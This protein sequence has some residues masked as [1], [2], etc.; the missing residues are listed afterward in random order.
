MALEPSKK[1]RKNPDK[2]TEDEKKLFDNINYDQIQAMTDLNT[3]R[4]L[5][6][7]MTDEGFPTTSEC[8]KE[9][10][11]NMGGRPSDEA[12]PVNIKQSEEEL[13]SFREELFEWE[14]DMKFQ[15]KDIDLDREE[16]HNR[17]NSAPIRKQKVVIG[18]NA[19]K[20]NKPLPKLEA[21]AAADKS[22]L[23]SGS[24]YFDK[25]DKFAK[26]EEAKL[27]EEDKRETTLSEKKLAGELKAQEEEEEENLAHQDGGTGVAKAAKLM[28]SLTP[29]EKKWHAKR[30]KEKGNE[31]F[32]AKEFSN[33]VRCY[34]LALKLDPGV[35]AV[36]NNR[37]AAYM[38]LKRWE[39]AELDCTFSLELEPGNFK[40]LLRRGAARIEM[41]RDGAIEGA[42]EDIEAALQQSPDDSELQ[43]LHDKALRKVR[44]FIDSADSKRMSR[45]QIQE[46]EDDSDEAEDDSDGEAGDDEEY[47]TISKRDAESEEEMEI[48]PEAEPEPEPEAPQPSKVELADEQRRQG[49]E[50][51]K[52]GK[53]A[54]AEAAYGCSLQLLPAAVPVLSNRAMVRLAL[55]QFVDAEADAD[56]ALALDPGFVKAYHRRYEAR[57]ALGK[58]QGALEDVRRV[59]K[60]APDT[61]G[62]A[63]AA[64]TLEKELE[65]EAYKP[66]RQGPMIIEELDS[67][68]DEAVQQ[69]SDPAQER[70]AQEQ[71]QAEIARKAAEAVEAQK[72]A[73]EESKESERRVAE[74]RQKESKKAAAESAKKA[75]KAKAE[76]AAQTAKRESQEAA[77]AEAKQL[78][79]AAKAG[80]AYIASRGWRGALVGYYFGLG[81]SGQGYYADP[82]S[83][84]AKK[85]MAE[86]EKAKRSA[87][88]AEKASSEEAMRQAEVAVRQAQ[89]KVEQ[90]KAEVS[91]PE[92]KRIVIEDDDDEE[93]E[94]EKTS[95]VD[96]E[97]AA[98]A[99]K[100]EGNALFKKGD[101][102]GAIGCYTQ[103]VEMGSKDA[104][105]KVAAY[106]NCA[107]AYLKMGEA[108]E[109]E[110][111]AT[112]ALALDASHVKAFHRRASA[113]TALGKKAEALEDLQKVAA[114]MPG[115]QQVQNEM[116]SLKMQLAGEA[117]QAEA[118][119]SA[120]PPTPAPE[121][122]RI[123]IQ[124]DDTDDEEDAAEAGAAPK[125]APPPTPA[126]ERKRIVIEEDDDDEEDEEEKPSDLDV[127]AAA[128]AKKEEGNA[129]FKKG[130]MRG[131][132]GCYTQC[133]EMDSKDAAVKVA[134][135]SNCAAAYLKMGEAKEAEAAA[136]AALALDAS[137]VKAFH[138]RA[139]ARTALGK[140]AEALEDLQKVA[141]GMPGNQQVQNEMASLKVQ[142]AGEAAQVEAHS[143]APPPTPAPE[144]KRIVI[145]EDDTDDEGEE[146]AEAEKA[147]KTA[148]PRT[149]APERKR[150]VIQEDDTD[151]EED[152]AEA[153]AAPKTAPPPTPAPQRKRIVIEDDDDEED[154]E[155]EKP[156]EVDVEAATAAKKEE[157]NALF[158]KGDMRG[159]IGCYTQCVEMGSKDAAVKVAAYSNCA[160]A[161]LKTG[162]AKEAE[163]AATAALA[164]D[165]SHVKAF[166]RRASARTALGKKAEALEDLQKVAAGMPGNQQVQNEMTSLKMQLAGEAAQ[167][168]AHS[169]APPP[170]PAPERKRIVIQ[171]DDTDDEEEASEAGAA[172]KTA[173]PPTL[174]PERKRIVIQEDDTDDEEEAA[175]AGAAPKT[176]PPP[177]PAPE[178]KRIV[179]EEDDDDEEDEEEKPSDLDV[180]AAAAAKK[181]EGNA[182]FKKGDM[183]GAIGCYTQCVEMG[184]KDAAVKVAA[185]SNCAAA[186]LKMGEAKEAEAAATAALALDASHVK[187][188][189]RRA[190]ARTALGKKAEALEDLQKVAAGMPGN[191]QVQNEMASLK[192]QLAGEAAQAEAHSSAPPPT[193][194][195]ERKRIAI[196]EDDTDDDEEETA[197]GHKSAPPRTP[198]PERKRI[199]IQ[200]DD[201][202]DEEEET[203]VGHKSAPPPTPAPECKRIVIEE[204][205]EDDAAAAGPKSAPT[206]APERKRIVIEEDDDDHEAAA[207]PK[208]TPPPPPIPERTH[209]KAD[210]EATAAATKEEGNALFKK[211][212]MRGAIACYTMCVG[213]GAHDVDVKT[214]A[215][216]NCAAA[217]LKVGE[218]E[219]AE[220][221]ASAALELTPHGS[222]HFKALHRRATARTSLGKLAEALQDLEKV[223]VAMPSNKTVVQELDALRR[224]LAASPAS[225]GSPAAPNKEAEA[226]HA[227]VAAVEA[228][229]ASAAAVVATKF[230]SRLP[231]PK[232]CVD[233]ERACKALQN[234]S[235]ALGTYVQQVEP[236]AYQSLFKDSMSG[237]ILKNIVVYVSKFLL[238]AAHFEQAYMTLDALVNVSRFSMA[239][240]LLPKPEKML[241]K[242]AFDAVANQGFDVATLRKEYRV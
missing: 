232:S 190:S 203:V 36:H 99:K 14:K 24:N 52:A 209:V 39:D 97:A 67:D 78:E 108:K 34:S 139:S 194:A 25:W 58:K 51:Y 186:Y 167:A 27:E 92:R 82:N 208:S 228:K 81:D 188:F 125:T 118:H 114:G 222:I 178:R 172:P 138:R 144:R 101:M 153:G 91:A 202:D 44:N 26:D 130:D 171:E 195:P 226:A 104:A 156:S 109:A 185:Y 193:P 16:V 7:Y 205:D 197:G 35:A 110:A 112:A 113:R 10:I 106:S 235:Q 102:R 57:R 11:L 119:S 166:H 80:E 72:K 128:A 49:N 59:L 182:L 233:F 169:S 61:P 165:A 220:D 173:P 141:A 133:V 48:V 116:A 189:H 123:V 71:R 21:A 3:L 41:E 224:S 180:E 100:E 213:M 28:E 69:A 117:A 242:S 107:A 163:A 134:A 129:L 46:I 37:A 157:G 142:L 216:S 136:T 217:H 43:G 29:M 122:K 74:M 65:D 15:E 148:P 115:N 33:A 198:A 162:E 40:G 184:S 60:E 240:M 187:A 77:K 137:H 181:E 204:E 140:K 237:P 146:A 168:E 1:T 4:K 127:E 96:V 164:L 85:A 103:C 105:V 124:E 76:N 229:A 66:M 53:Y 111:A 161:Y 90:A 23:R 201:T 93:D 68:D 31:A 19:N 192:V 207:G 175:E 56:L 155:E 152:A 149:P 121:R 145:Q 62:L 132:I 88:E 45:V 20:E 230:V 22:D 158:K 210:V 151:D 42:V 241:L 131:A 211:G 70:Q 170:T 234:D 206:P 98:A 221:A 12:D 87:A 83:P 183:R 89:D 120:P 239:V 86:A 54:E 199:V 95:E 94:E 214:A 64:R 218:A 8:V 55:K 50:L 236:S 17:P 225:A 212:D 154:E 159:A 231:P 75:E 177:T 147:P 219:E 176:A 191:Q 63:K 150:I 2:I 30:E 9:R 38:K 126:P 6:K 143:S 18:A 160:A 227:E 179:I 32:K 13:A 47:V 238:P 73:E 174:A 135:Y 196:Q 200:E 79:D 84:A 5:E 223:A 215:Y